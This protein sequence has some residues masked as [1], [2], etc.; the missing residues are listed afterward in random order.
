MEGRCAKIEEIRR[1]GRDTDKNRHERRR[2]NDCADWLIR[3]VPNPVVLC[4][5]I[6]TPKPAGIFGRTELLTAQLESGATFAPHPF[7]PIFVFSTMNFIRQF[8]VERKTPL[9]Y[10]LA[11][12]FRNIWVFRAFRN[13]NGKNGLC[14]ILIWQ[15]H[16]RTEKS[17][18]MNKFLEYWSDW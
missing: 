17:S 7:T 3:L 2:K 16:E 8:Q 10:R 1:D 13:S 6:P 11:L 5:K 4:W 18:R 12:N 15:S 14:E 9:L